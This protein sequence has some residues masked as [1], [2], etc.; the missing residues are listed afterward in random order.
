MVLC[1]EMVALSPVVGTGVGASLGAITNFCLGRAWIFQRN[2]GH[3][4]TQA[5]RYALASAAGAG[6]NALGEHLANDLAHVQY[7][8][9]RALVAVV[10]SLF[11]NFPM[12]RRFVF[13]E[14]GPA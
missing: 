2:T 3:P 8:L 7:V 11:W 14:A 12:Q 5:A 6:W 9:A 13:R 4:A 10:V 1:V